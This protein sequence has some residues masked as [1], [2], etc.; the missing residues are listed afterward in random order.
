MQRLEVKKFADA[1]E[2]ELKEND[3]KKG[4]KN[5]TSGFLISKLDEETKELLEVVRAYKNINNEELLHDDMTELKARILSEAADVGNIA[6]MIADI[7][8]ALQVENKE[9]PMIVC[10]CGSTRFFK[11]FDEQ[12]FR[13]TL[14]G[15]I[16]L[17]IG[18][19]T[20]SDDGLKLTAED[21]LR[22]DELHKRKIDL[23]NWVLVLDVDGY[24]GESTRS[25]ID[26]ANRLG[27][28]VKYLSQKL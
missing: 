27:K 26:Y 7:C 25:E 21:K 22:L 8:G 19:N 28:P 3:H 15:Y 1:M 23:C 17:S 9:L 11:T 13:L 4:W 2:T 12:N 20:K 18:C 14:E 6:M 16:V 5:C 24:I 10:L